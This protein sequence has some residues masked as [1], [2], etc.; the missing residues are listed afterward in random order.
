MG[1]ASR[2]GGKG[3]NQA[4]AV[5]RAGGSV[6]FVGAVGTDGQWLKEKMRAEGVGV[7]GLVLDEACFISRLFVLRSLRVLLLSLGRA[8][9]PRDYPGGQAWRE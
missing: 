5:A 1:H 3:A 9:W 4:V 2:I 7:D 6:Q 8:N